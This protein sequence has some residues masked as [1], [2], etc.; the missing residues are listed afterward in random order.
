MEMRL[1]GYYFYLGG[2]IRVGTRVDLPGGR[3]IPR[4]LFRDRSE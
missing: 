3:T 2:G 4:Q 1:F